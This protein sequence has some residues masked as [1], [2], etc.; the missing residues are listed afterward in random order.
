MKMDMNALQAENRSLREAAT[1]FQHHNAFQVAP[2]GSQQGSDDVSALTDLLSN[3]EQRI[4]TK[5]AGI[6]GSTIPS[7]TVGTTVTTNSKNEAELLAQAKQRDPR[8][9]KN[10]N[11]GKGKRFNRYCW[12]C[13][14]NTTHSS[15]SCYQLSKSDR[16]KY[17]PATVTNHMGG[18][19]HF[20]DRFNKYQAD[21]NFDSL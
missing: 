2:Y 16:T 12:H 20:I 17:K 21:Y 3:F 13:G 9:Y 8:D 7:T 19:E 1:S 15:Q 10:L 4:D 6:L 14:C 11:N 18:S 5:I